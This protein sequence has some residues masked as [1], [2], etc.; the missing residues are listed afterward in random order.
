MSAVF[1]AAI[2]VLLTTASLQPTFAHTRLRHNDRRLEASGARPTISTHN[3]RDRAEQDR[4][5]STRKQRGAEHAKRRLASREESSNR[6]IYPSRQLRTLM[7]RGAGYDVPAQA[8]ITGQVATV[9]SDQSPIFASREAGGQLLARVDK[10]T[11]IL[12][13][14]QT[15]AYYAVAMSNHTLGFI[16]KTDA[17][18]QNLQV[19]AS[20][21]SDELPT[22]AGAADQ[23]RQTL[24][25]DSVSPVAKTI[26]QSAFNCLGVV[27]YQYGGTTAA[28]IDCS[29]FIQAVYG[30]SGVKLPRTAAQQAQ[31]GDNVPLRDMTQWMPG[32]RMYFQCHHDYIDHTGMYIGNGY[33][34]HSSIDHHGV[35]IDQVASEYYWDHLV[36]V[37]RSPEVA[38]STGTPVATPDYESNQE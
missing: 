22:A 36:A 35:N 5:V 14:G 27:P 12:V 28:G 8:P 1:T 11:P 34:I 29:A 20:G 26:L 3:R 21:A 31:V 24:T 18:L 10:G 19:T 13:T 32:D 7:S 37:R 38:N 6:N 15:D 4:S 25:M 17:Q 33:F 16:A 30:A 2:A 9:L 23:S